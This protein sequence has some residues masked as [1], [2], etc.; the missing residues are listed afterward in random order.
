MYSGNHCVFIVYIYLSGKLEKSEQACKDQKNSHCHVN[1][2][3]CYFHEQKIFPMNS[4]IDI[5]FLSF[6]S[7][8]FYY[9]FQACLLCISKE[10]FIVLYQHCKSL[11]KY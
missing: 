11:L 6:L 8:I 9:Y 3:V 4:V 2:L 5:M 10:I 1:L 7:N